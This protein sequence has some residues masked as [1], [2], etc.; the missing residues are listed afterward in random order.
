MAGH[1]AAS[2]MLSL[3]MNTNAGGPWAAGFRMDSRFI[4]HAM[5][6]DIS[7]SAK[8]RLEYLDGPVWRIRHEMRC[9]ALR[10]IGSHAA[11]PTRR[12]PGQLVLQQSTQEFFHD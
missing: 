9:V 7:V 10:C 11:S 3:T 2:R 5:L 6:A 12:G 4:T 8:F 1:P